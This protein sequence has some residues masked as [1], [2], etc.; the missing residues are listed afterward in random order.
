ME[1]SI[2][3]HNNMLPKANPLDCDGVHSWVCR[4][5]NHGSAECKI[6]NARTVFLA[7]KAAFAQL[8]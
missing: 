7:T 1:F 4:T 3:Q 2:Q 5:T 6:V 8:W